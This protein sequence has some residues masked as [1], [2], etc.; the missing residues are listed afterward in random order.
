M[1]M[2][3]SSQI[4]PS[5]KV[6]KNNKINIDKLTSIILYEVLKNKYIINLIE[7]HHVINTK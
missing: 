7:K 3:K 6:V 5:L 4:W 2:L 1:V